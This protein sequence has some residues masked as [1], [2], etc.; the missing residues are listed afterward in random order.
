[1]QFDRLKRREFITL[2]GGVAARG[3]GAAGR[4]DAAHRRANGLC[5]ERSGIKVRTRNVCP[6]A[7]EIGLGGRPYFADRHSLADTLER[8]RYTEWHRRHLVVREE[9]LSG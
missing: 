5:G 6:G 1:M 2:L 4:V 7:A 3:A 9:R 8:G